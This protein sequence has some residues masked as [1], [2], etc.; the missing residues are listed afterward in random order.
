VSRGAAA[1]LAERGQIVEAQDAAQGQHGVEQ[2]GF[3]AGRQDEAIPVE[4][5]GIGRIE[6]QELLEKHVYHVGRGHGAARMTG[7]GLAGGVHDE[8]FDDVDG[9]A[10]HIGGSDSHDGV[11]G[12]AG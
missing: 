1:E 11:L 8:A 4:P 7:F 3:V 10:V 2:H 6:A 12:K 9:L 5:C